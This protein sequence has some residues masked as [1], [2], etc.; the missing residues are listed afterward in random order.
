MPCPLQTTWERYRNTTLA[1]LA[2]AI[3]SPRDGV[4]VDA[5]APHCQS[6]ANG[7][8]ETW[9]GVEIGGVSPADAFAAWLAGGAGAPGAKLVDRAPY[10]SNPSCVGVGAHIHAH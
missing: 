8:G 6:L 3:A 10:P 5:C 2:A 9:T 7:H 4:F 1:N